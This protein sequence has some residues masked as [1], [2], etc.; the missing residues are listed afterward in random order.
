MPIAQM[1][2]G[3]V[4]YYHVELPQHSA[5]LAEGLP[6]ESYL[7][8]GDRAN[9]ANGMHSIA[10]HPDF[11]SRQWEAKEC[12]RIV[13]TGLELAA[14][15]RWVEAIASSEFQFDGRTTSGT[16]HVAR[17]SISTHRRASPLPAAV[18]PRPPVAPPPPRTCVTRACKPH[19]VHPS[20]LHHARHG[21]GRQPSR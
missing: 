7:D 8:T 9:F 17:M 6:A 11:S 3:E 12:A 5:L 21:I 1:A 18:V 15:R 10:L 20:V 4:T 16:V 19:C 14:A 13:V 2:M